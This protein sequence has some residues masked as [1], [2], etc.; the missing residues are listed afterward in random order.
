M[1]RG[2]SWQAIISDLPRSLIVTT[3]CV[4]GSRVLLAVSMTSCSTIFQSP[5]AALTDEQINQ[6]Y[7]KRYHP[8]VLTAADK[9]ELRKMAGEVRDRVVDNDVV[10]HC[11]C[12]SWSNPI[13]QKK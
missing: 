12:N 7:C 6:G 5:D 11:V 3:L 2:G 8:V 13:C 4:I 10:Y 9:A 1:Q